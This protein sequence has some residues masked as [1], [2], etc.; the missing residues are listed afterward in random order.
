MVAPLTLPLLVKMMMVMTDDPLRKG[1]VVTIVITGTA[2]GGVVAIE[3]CTLPLLVMILQVR[4]KLATSISEN[5][6]TSIL[7]RISYSSMVRG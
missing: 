2:E 7:L 1:T 3:G 4:M 5:F 6:A